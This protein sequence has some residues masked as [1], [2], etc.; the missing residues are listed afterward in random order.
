MPQVINEMPR[1]R[2]ANY[3]WDEWFDGTPRNFVKGEDFY[4]KPSSFRTVAYL[5]AKNKGVQITTAIK[6]DIVS[7]QKIDD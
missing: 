2:R 3:R 5:T 4:C 7:I 1:P 6:G